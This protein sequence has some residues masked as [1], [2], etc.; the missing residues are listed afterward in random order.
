VSPDNAALNLG[1]NDFSADEAGEAVGRLLRDKDRHESGS[2]S[3]V[4][5]GR[6]QAVD[7]RVN[8]V[9]YGRSVL[10]RIKVF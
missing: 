9:M 8:V 4:E 7:E 10:L 1:T 3:C 2:I 5:R 6:F